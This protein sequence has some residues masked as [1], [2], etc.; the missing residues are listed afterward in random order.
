MCAS[1]KDVAYKSINENNS[2][3]WMRELCKNN[4]IGNEKEV[5]AAEN[6]LLKQLIEEMKS[7][8]CILQDNNALLKEIQIQMKR[9]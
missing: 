3:F 6:A 7:K 5:L 1:V 8:N 2:I 9:T 4:T